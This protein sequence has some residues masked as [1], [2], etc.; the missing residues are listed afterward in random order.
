MEKLIFL[1]ICFTH[2]ILGKAEGISLY[3]VTY[4]NKSEVLRFHEIG[5]LKVITSIRKVPNTYNLCAIWQT[6]NETLAKSIG[7]LTTVRDE[8]DD[9]KKAYEVMKIAKRVDSMEIL[10]KNIGDAILDLIDCKNVSITKSTPEIEKNGRAKRQTLEDFVKDIVKDVDKKFELID[11]I[12]AE[13]QDNIVQIKKTVNLMVDWMAISDSF[14]KN[15][16]K[17]FNLLQYNVK[18]LAIFQEIERNIDGFGK[19]MNAIW[20]VMETN[21]MNSDLIEIEDFKTA[22]DKLPND[23]ESFIYKSVREFYN[24]FPVDYSIENNGDVTLTMNIPLINEDKKF[25]LHQIE[26]VPLMLDGEKPN[27]YKLMDKKWEYLAINGDNFTF[28]KDIESCYRTKNKQSEQT[29]FCELQSPI[30]SEKGHDDCIAKVFVRKAYDN[31]TDPICNEL[32]ATKSYSKTHFEKNPITPNRYYFFIV[33]QEEIEIFYKGYDTQTANLSSIGELDLEPGSL[34]KTKNFMLTTTKTSI[35]QRKIRTSEI[36]MTASDEYIQS[37]MNISSQPQ[38][39]DSISVDNSDVSGP[40][41]E[42]PKVENSPL[43]A[44]L[45]FGEIFTTEFGISMISFI[46]VIVTIMCGVMFCVMNN[47]FNRKMTNLGQQIDDN[48]EQM[49]RMDSIRSLHSENLKGEEQ[50]LQELKQ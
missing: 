22:V 7:N 50:E 23:S 31:E 28:F 2:V 37:L 47:H 36:F 4:F 32:L 45:K 48:G 34:A 44:S 17:S 38:K 26:A 9:S 40:R 21:R 1:L 10:I 35:E 18:F 39:N 6:T 49:E 41:K 19:K 20:R 8:N 29:I 42:T 3:N 24:Q 43:T 46:I 27:T 13:T 16:T 12:N 5:N 15:T 11:E 25:E 33:D 30:F 14:S